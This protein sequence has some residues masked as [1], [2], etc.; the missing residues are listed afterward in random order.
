MNPFSSFLDEI[1]SL[2]SARTNSRVDANKAEEVSQFFQ[3]FN[4]LEKAP[5]LIVIAATNRP[6]H[7]D[8]VPVLTAISLRKLYRERKR[9]PVPLSTTPL[10]N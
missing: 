1:D 8:P 6:D 9:E 5:N 3:E 7:L 2:V 10:I 4:E